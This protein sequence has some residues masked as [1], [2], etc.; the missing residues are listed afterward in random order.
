M[1]DLS[2]IPSFFRLSIDSDSD[3]VPKRTANSSIDKLN[4]D[5]ILV[6]TITTYIP[7]TDEIAHV[8]DEARYKSEL[9]SKRILGEE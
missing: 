7:T 8:M 5:D 4:E 1:V 9:I 6:P 2:Y 3:G